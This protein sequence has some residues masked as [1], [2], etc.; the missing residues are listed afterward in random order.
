MASSPVRALSDWVLNG[1][2]GALAG[3]AVFAALYLATQ[4]ADSVVDRHPEVDGPET[5]GSTVL[6]A[7]G[8]GI[9]SSV[10]LGLLVAWAAGLPRPWAV[11]LLGLMFSGLLICGWGALKIPAF[12]SPRLLMVTL[13]VVA[14]ALAAVATKE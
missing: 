8:V 5:V 9:P 1:L 3:L 13:I 11:S 14:Y 6:I 12:A 10:I 2:R 4:Y 7:L